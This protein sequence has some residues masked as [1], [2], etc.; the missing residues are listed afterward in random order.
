MEEVTPKVAVVVQ[1]EKAGK[2]LL[3]RQKEK[4]PSELWC[5]PGGKLEAQ[6]GIE[7]CARRE[8]FEE[9][10]VKL[11][12]VKVV[13]VQNFPVIFKYHW[14]T[15]I[16]KARIESGKPMIRETNKIIEIQ[17]FNKKNLPQNLF[18]STKLFFQGDYYKIQGKKNK[19]ML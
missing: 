7:E 18:D 19:L 14:I 16:V 8:A 2:I 13:G 6:E 12:D 11:K 5:F 4:I 10:G 15:F 9:L 3:I 17:W 1:I